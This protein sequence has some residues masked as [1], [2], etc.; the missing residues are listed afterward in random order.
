MVLLDR[1]RDLLQQ[2]RLAGARRR[3]DQATLA[4]ADRRHHVDDARAQFIGRGLQNQALVRVQRR[5]ILE[6]RR[7]GFL[8]RRMS[9]DQLHLHQCEV[10]LSLDG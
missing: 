1:Q 6:H 8:L 10:L 4:L 5:Q 3:H 7:A 9:I 2:H